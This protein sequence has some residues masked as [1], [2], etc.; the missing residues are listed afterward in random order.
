MDTFTGMTRTQETQISMV[1]YYRVES[2][3]VTPE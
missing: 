3:E 2:L 1:V